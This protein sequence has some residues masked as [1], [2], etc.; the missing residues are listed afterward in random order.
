MRQR[1]DPRPQP[2]PVAQ[3]EA[4]KHDDDKRLRPCQGRE[5]LHAHAEQGRS[6]PRMPVGP[7]ATNVDEDRVACGGEAADRDGLAVRLMKVYRGRGRE[8][9]RDHE[10]LQ[11]GQ[12][13]VVTFY[14]HELFAPSSAL[15]C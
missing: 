10:R 6:E 3:P 15:P 4:E 7:R 13:Q 5:I 12:E 9:N 2:D 8:T 1:R 14:F 11:H